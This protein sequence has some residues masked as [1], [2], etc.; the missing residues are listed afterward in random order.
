MA[1]IIDIEKK[2][3]SLTIQDNFVFA[4]TMESNPDLCR[5]ILELIL[6]IKIKNISYPEREK[7]VD[8]RTDSKGIRIDVYVEDKSTNRSFDIEMQISNNDN[9]AKRIRYYQGL[10]D[11]D[12]LQ[13]GKKYR[14]LGESFIIF[15]CT[16]DYFHKGKHIYTF[17]EFC[18]QDFS[19]ALNDGSTKIFLNTTGTEDDVNK[20][21]K[22]FLD[23]IA[24][25][26]IDSPMISELDK[27]VRQVK[28]NEK[29]RL[30]YVTYELAL[31]EREERG[32]EIGMKR[33]FEIGEMK[34]A[35]KIAIKMLKKGDSVEKVQ[36]LTELPI[37]HVQE[38][39]DSINKN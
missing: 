21:V 10:I 23:Y 28:S 31:Q 19:I 35:E 3:D 20:D 39:S 14:A 9:L 34:K 5:H 13:K 32:L 4:K 7:T 38:L 37:K 29:W 25:N 22:N 1:N 8:M 26:H 24:G 33:G 2:W 30:E 17:R 15:I 12:K 16:F 18:Q 6:N 27:T 11:M 36:D